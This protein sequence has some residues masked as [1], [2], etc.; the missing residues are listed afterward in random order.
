[1]QIKTN[2]GSLVVSNPNQY[3]DKNHKINTDYQINYLK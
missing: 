2:M 3:K 1:M